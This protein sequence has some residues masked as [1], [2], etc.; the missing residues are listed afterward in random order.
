MSFSKKLGEKEE[1]EG[2][3]GAREGGKKGGG[4]RRR[5]EGGRE[6]KKN[7]LKHAPYNGLGSWLSEETRM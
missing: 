4:K 7:I 5:K 3:E 1:K 2:R 6:G